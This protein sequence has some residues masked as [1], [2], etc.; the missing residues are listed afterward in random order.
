MPLP[1]LRFERGAIDNESVVVVA[2]ASKHEGEY[3]SPSDSSDSEYT[4]GTS[5]G[6]GIANGPVAESGVDSGTSAKLRARRGCMCVPLAFRADLWASES[7]EVLGESG[8][9]QPGR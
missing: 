8:T 6:G 1:T 2:L 7:G 3:V 4:S 9:G 5:G